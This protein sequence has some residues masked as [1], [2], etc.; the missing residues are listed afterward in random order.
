MFAATAVTV[1][2]AVLGRPLSGVSV[3]VL[4]PVPDTWNDCG[5]LLHETVNELAVTS[6]GSVKFTVISVDGSTSEAPSVGVV[7]VTAGA[8]SVVNEKSKSAAMVSGGSTVSTSLTWFATT[9]TEQSVPSGRS[10]SGFSVIDEPGEPLSVNAVGVPV[11]HAS[12]NAPAEA[13]TGSLKV[14]MM[15]VFTA[16]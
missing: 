1:H 4:V 11:G 10:A 7:V 3:I 12:V 15:F 5:L 14:T 2:D 16:T 8:A 9:M 13:V 6:T